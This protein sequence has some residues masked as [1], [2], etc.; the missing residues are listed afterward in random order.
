LYRKLHGLDFLTAD[1]AIAEN[2]QPMNRSCFQVPTSPSRLHAR[3]P[4]ASPIAAL[5][6]VL[7]AAAPP[8]TGAEPLNLELPDMGD[9]TGTL[10]TAQQEHALGEAFFRNLHN[11][12]EIEEDPEITDYIQSLGQKLVENSDTP[13]Q[14]FHFFVVIEPAI[15]AFAGPGGYI[16]VNSGLILTTEAESELASVL[17]HEIAHVTQ[18]HLYQAFQAAGRLSLPTAAAMLAAVLIGAKTG[19]GQ[20]SQAAIMAASAASAQYQ[21]NFTRDNEA[22][23]DRVGMKILA[24]SHFDP[25]S[26]P[27]FFERMQQSTR[28]AGRDIPE[29]LLT[30][31]VTV[32]RISDTRGRAEQYPYRQFPDSFTYQIIK[33]KLHVRTARNPQESV[34]YF[35]SISDLG[36]QEQQDVARYGLAQALIAQGKI[37]AGKPLL[38]ELIRHYP[39]QSQFY[40]ALAGAELESKNYSA[41]LTVFDAALKRF[42]NNRA[43]HLNLARTLLRTGQAAEARRRLQEYLFRFPATPEIYALLAQAC[44]QL[45][46]EADSHR[47]LAEHY[48]AQG[49]TRAAI[50]Q[51]KLAQKSPGRNFQ[52]DSA[53]EERLKELLEEEK[54]QREH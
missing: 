20:L 46:N 53:I 1:F 51:L 6:A 35:T 33:A 49:Q 12:V 3:I 29:F 2:F 32:S 8:S 38:E 25:R 36:T 41:V 16:G 30:H 50:L 23:A 11:R 4:Q 28:F 37:E 26:M 15:N 42:P 13:S 48:Y 34:T 18:R 22:E 19:S 21:I 9:P 7:L 17:A 39:E 27:T 44:S 24:A 52:T 45:G 40:N 5:L 14:P 43:L 54:E 47:F 10:F 31:P